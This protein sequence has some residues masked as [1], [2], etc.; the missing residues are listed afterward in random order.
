MYIFSDAPARPPISQ[1]TLYGLGRLLFTASPY[2]LVRRYIHRMFDRHRMKPRH[3][4]CVCMGIRGRTPGHSLSLAY[5]ALF[6]SERVHYG[7]WAIGLR[8]PVILLFPELNRVCTSR[9]LRTAFCIHKIVS[10]NNSLAS[11]S[12]FSLDSNAV[13]FCC[14]T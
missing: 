9:I 4:G 12:P 13:R 8:H 14:T 7:S 6:I 2:I 3:L 5:D 10:H 11:I 1:R